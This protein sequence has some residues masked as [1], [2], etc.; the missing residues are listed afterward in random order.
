MKAFEEKKSLKEAL[1]AN[2]E[3]AAKMKPV[4]VDTITDP[5]NYI[6]TAVEQVD[7]VLRREGYLR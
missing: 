7:E 1:L 6:G 3:I 2:P 4:E 5:E